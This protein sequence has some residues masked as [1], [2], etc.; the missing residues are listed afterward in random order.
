MTTRDELLREAH[1]LAQKGADL[2]PEDIAR[3]DVLADEV[4][5]ADAAAAAR[6]DAEKRLSAVLGTDRPEVKA[7]AAGAVERRAK[8]A[9][10]LFVTSDAWQAFKAQHASGF[11]AEHDVVDVYV[12][13]LAAKA[14]VLGSAAATTGGSRFHLG[15]PVD[16]EMDLR[17]GALLQAVTQ[18][19]TESTVLP[20]RALTAVAPG[21]E[22][23]PEATTDSGTGTAGGVK[24]LGAVTTRAETA[25]VET[26]AE[27]IPV[28]NAE[29]ADDQVL[30]SLLDDVLYVLVMQKVEG[31]IVSGTGSPG[32]IRGI[33]GATGVQSQAFATDVPTSLRKARTL[34]GDAAAR[35]TIVLNPLDAE[36]LDLLQDKQGRYLSSGIFGGGDS[37]VWR[38]PVIESTAV[39]AKTAVVGDLSAYEVRW[40]ERYAARLFNQHADYALRNLSLLL[41]EARL[42][43]VFRR[44]RDVVVVKLS[45]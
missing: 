33:I 45:A 11:S 34:L 6:A 32:Q 31:A 42:L 13:N 30:I 37:K 20:Y 36:G 14:S 23:V 19:D 9:G 39:P 38:M 16:A 26:V 35:A 40:R 22:F 17:Q 28:T 18:S 21:P 12:R 43:G 2:T 4:A 44:R 1:A 24:P 25:V 15:S 41:A 7:A 8:S 3:I 29:V 27:G 5:K 10:E